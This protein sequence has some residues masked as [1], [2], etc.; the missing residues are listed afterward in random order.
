MDGHPYMRGGADG[1]EKNCLIDSLRQTLYM[2]D[3]NMRSVRKDLMDEFGVKDE[4]EPH[5]HVTINSYLDAD[6]HW[7]AILISLRKQMHFAISNYRIVVLY[8]DAPD[9]GVVLGPT[10]ASQ[11]LVIINQGD[12]HFE[13][14]FRVL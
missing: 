7:Y 14:C 13:P 5:K 10:T 11:S 2:H 12:M 8:A 6:Y 4:A 1:T 3:C 9:N